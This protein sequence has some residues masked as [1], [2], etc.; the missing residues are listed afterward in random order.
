VA[1]RFDLCYPE[2]KLIIEYDGASPCLRRRAVEPR[3]RTAG[4]A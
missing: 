2:Y 3:P 4:M 1:L